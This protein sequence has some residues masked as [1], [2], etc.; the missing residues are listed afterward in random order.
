MNLQHI[1]KQ[2]FG[3]FNIIEVAKS[4]KE[5]KNFLV[6]MSKSSL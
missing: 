2:L 1:L 4:I 5:I 6:M 3:T